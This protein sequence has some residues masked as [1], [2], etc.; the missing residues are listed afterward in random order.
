MLKGF[1]TD[2]VMHGS[3]ANILMETNLV[4]SVTNPSGPKSG[5][6]RVGCWFETAEDCRAAN[7]YGI[8]G[9]RVCLSPSG[10]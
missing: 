4:Y 3:L 6:G 5:S 2:M 10:Q 9:F 7:R 8:I 1:V